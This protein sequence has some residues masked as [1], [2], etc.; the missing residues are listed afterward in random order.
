MHRNVVETIL[1]AVVLLVAIG[2]LIWAYQ[3]SNVGDPGGYTLVASF[4]RVDGL[5]VGSDVRISGIK[6]GKV[7]SQTLDDKTYRADVRFSVRDGVELPSDSSAAVV[8]SSLLGG[9]YLALQ[10]GADD[11]M[12]AN[13]DRISFTQSAVNLE[14]LIGR[15]VF[16][17]QGGGG[18]GGQAPSGEG[19]GEAGGKPGGGLF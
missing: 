10:P 19:G 8:S 1:G 17:S 2:F 7:L 6:V 14:D 16:G 9:K 15:Y 3:R 5:E 18:G 11:K 4:D 12:L 13:G